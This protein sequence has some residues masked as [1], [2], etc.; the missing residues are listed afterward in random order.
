MAKKRLA[1]SESQFREWFGDIDGRRL[2]ERFCSCFSKQT[3]WPDGWAHCHENL[4]QNVMAWSG[5]REERRADCSSGCERASGRTW[6]P[7]REHTTAVL[8]VFF[9]FVPETEG[10]VERLRNEAEVADF[11]PSRSSFSNRIKTHAITPIDATAARVAGG[12]Y[13]R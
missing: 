11:S 3:T 7:V 6:V 8:H 10:H 12:N 1:G 2:W 5:H 13:G 9:V 4:R